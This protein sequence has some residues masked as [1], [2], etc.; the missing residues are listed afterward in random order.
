MRRAADKQP[1]K[2]RACL[3]SNLEAAPI[4]LGEQVEKPRRGLTARK[5]IPDA[6][7]S[8]SPIDRALR[9]STDRRAV[10]GGDECTASRQS[11]A[12]DVDKAAIQGWWRRA[13]SLADSVR[14]LA[15]IPRN[16]ILALATC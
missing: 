9:V 6:A 7:K 14:S 12:M 5:S 13:W 16:R 10:V 15:W 4:M 3:P 1:A 11:F 8:Y 2:S